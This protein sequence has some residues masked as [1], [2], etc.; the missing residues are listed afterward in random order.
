M[1]GPGS[2]SAGAIDRDT[3]LR[4]ADAVKIAFPFGGMTVSGLR[5]EIARGHLAIEIIAGKHFTTL[6]AIE[7]MREKCRLTPRAR[8]SIC[9][10]SA[11]AVPLT[12]SSETGNVSA[13][14]DAAQMTLRALKKPSTSTSERPALRRRKAPVIHLTSLSRT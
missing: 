4:L 3:P 12:G 5:R 2:P 8:G 7:E 11:V 14:L 13:A 9:D 1:S 6:G 10:A